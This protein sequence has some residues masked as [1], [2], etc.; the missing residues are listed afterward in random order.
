MRIITGTFTLPA[1]TDP[2][3]A[4]LMHVHRHAKRNETFP[5]PASRPA[6]GRLI[7]ASAWPIKPHSART[8][9]SYTA[10]FLSGGGQDAWGY[11]NYDAANDELM[12]D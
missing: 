10:E 7:L 3:V 4:D 5:Q 8:Y 2:I 9:A 12:A 11:R 1:L 6:D